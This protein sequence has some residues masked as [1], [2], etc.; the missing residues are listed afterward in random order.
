MIKKQRNKKKIYSKKRVL[1]GGERTDAVFDSSGVLHSLLTGSESLLSKSSILTQ[2]VCNKWFNNIRRNENSN[3][4]ID[5]VTRKLILNEQKEIKNA[6]KNARSAI[7][8]CQ[9]NRQT[10][11]EPEEPLFELEE[12]L[13]E[14]E[15]QLS[16]KL[17]ELKK[18]LSNNNHS[19][20]YEICQKYLEDV[21]NGCMEKLLESIQSLNF[22]KNDVYTN[23]KLLF[24]HL[25][26]KIV[27]P[28]PL[29][30]A[31]FT[32]TEGFFIGIEKHHPPS[33]PKVFDYFTCYVFRFFDDF[34]ND[35]IA[36]I[37]I[38]N[39]KTKFVGFKETKFV[40]YEETKPIRHQHR[41]KLFLV[42]T[43]VD[44]YYISIMQR[45]ISSY[46]P[47]LFLET[48]KSMKRANLPESV[49][50]LLQEYYTIVV[51]EVNDPDIPVDTIVVD[52]LNDPDIT[53]IPDEG[54]RAEGGGSKSRRKNSHKSKAKTHRHRRGS[55]SK[56]KSRRRSHSRARKHKK[57]TRRH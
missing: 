28:V 30:A 57:Y 24:E 40:R 29:S 15:E 26:F 38:D 49:L 53:D 56:S 34:V 33:M 43:Y 36:S 7:K 35:L 12:P 19:Y 21:F 55:K 32:L 52:E 45:C 17:E 2:D 13:F 42:L 25:E 14:L 23:I 54:A 37:N 51:N 39:N 31:N 44:E 9:E 46:K 27:D 8:F 6:T 18:L 50:R 41:K 47:V 22:G 10:Q 20:A 11:L 48:L 1:R 3:N 16:E 4:I 5:P